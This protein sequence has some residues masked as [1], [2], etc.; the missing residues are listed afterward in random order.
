M[1]P[2]REPSL[3][4]GP[5]VA[6]VA[7]PRCLPQGCR[8]HASPPLALQRPHR[9]WPSRNRELKR[10]DEEG[11][12]AW[13]GEAAAAAEMGITLEPYVPPTMDDLPKMQTV[14]HEQHPFNIS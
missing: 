8:P 13:A 3:P 5:R 11:R 7:R 1:S 10:R 4:R 9:L 14:F 2:R 12:A 6:A